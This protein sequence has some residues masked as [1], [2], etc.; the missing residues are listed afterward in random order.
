MY[1]YYN[2]ILGGGIKRYYLPQDHPVS[3][4]VSEVSLSSLD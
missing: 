1:Y 3:Q 4:K 2:K